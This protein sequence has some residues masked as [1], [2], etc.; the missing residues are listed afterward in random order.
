M[1]VYVEY[2][3]SILYWK[4]YIYLFKCLII[5]IWLLYFILL[6]CIILLFHVT[7]YYT[8]YRYRKRLPHRNIFLR[9]IWQLAIVNCT[10]V[11]LII[12]MGHL[13][14]QHKHLYNPTLNTQIF[15]WVN[16]NISYEILFQLIQPIQPTVSLLTQTHVRIVSMNSE[17]EI[18]RINRLQ[19]DDWWKCKLLFSI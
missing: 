18:I 16:I 13:E 17:W 14:N 8:L 10:W 5:S 3:A 2:I 6:Y 4:L 1:S 7:W 19:C 12:W 11:V 15:P 9:N